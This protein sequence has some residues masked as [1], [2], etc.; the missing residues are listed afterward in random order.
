[1]VYQSFFAN[2]VSLSRRIPALAADRVHARVV[3][4]LLTVWIMFAVAF[5]TLLWR[6]GELSN[7]CCLAIMPNY[8][9]NFG[10]RMAMVSS[11]DGIKG[12][13]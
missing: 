10:E 4:D 7:R 3:A 9:A 13:H 12:V 11:V 1:M 2:I 6:E 5:L 8:D